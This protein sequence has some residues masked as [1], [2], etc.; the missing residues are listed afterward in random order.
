LRVKINGI[1][2]SSSKEEVK[3]MA[4]KNVY[5]AESKEQ[6]HEILSFIELVQD[7]GVNV[8]YS[9][10]EHFAIVTSFSLPI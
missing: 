7:Y 4:E 3:T 2:N 1:I 10:K 9:N 5:Y 6:L 8:D